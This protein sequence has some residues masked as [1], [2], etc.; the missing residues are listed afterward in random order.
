[1]MMPDKLA[2]EFRDFDLLAVEFGN[3]LRTPV[4]REERKLLR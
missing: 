1:M 4:L 2:L 3:D